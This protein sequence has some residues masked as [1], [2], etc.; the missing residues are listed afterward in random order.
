VKWLKELEDGDLPSLTFYGLVCDQFRSVGHIP[1]SLD[2]SA[3]FMLGLMEGYDEAR[4]PDLIS[5][6]RHLFMAMVLRPAV[7]AAKKKPKGPR[8]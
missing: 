5:D 7:K 3:C 2:V 4:L 8:R 1:A 6:A